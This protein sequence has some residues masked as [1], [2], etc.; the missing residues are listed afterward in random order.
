MINPIDLQVG[1]INRIFDNFPSTQFQSINELNPSTQTNATSNTQATEPTSSFSEILAQR[2]SEKTD[3]AE[4]DLSRII[5]EEMLAAIERQGLSSHLLQLLGSNVNLNTDITRLL[6][7]QSPDLLNTPS[8]TNVMESLSSMIN[9]FG[10]TDPLNALQLYSSS[11][12]LPQSNIFSMF[13][14]QR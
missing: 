9:L 14:Q 5:N 11:V 10:G 2:L 13:M 7:I 4:Y 1:I 12:R 3:H 8:I 6:P